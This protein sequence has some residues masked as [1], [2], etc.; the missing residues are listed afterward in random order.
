MDRVPGAGCRAGSALEPAEAGRG[1]RSVA[2][3]RPCPVF[4]L[5][6]LVLSHNLER[7]AA[8]AALL[9]AELAMARGRVRELRMSRTQRA[10]SQTANSTVSSSPSLW[11]VKGVSG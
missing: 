8:G 11:I 4:T 3:I 9:N 5:R 1:R 10:V 6:F 2:R 7:G